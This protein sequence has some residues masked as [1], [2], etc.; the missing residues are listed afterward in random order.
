MGSNLETNHSE[1]FQHSQ[2]CENS[3]RMSWD[4]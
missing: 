2:E 1:L 3:D 4:L